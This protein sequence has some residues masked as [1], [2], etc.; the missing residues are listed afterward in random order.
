MKA[1]L[2]IPS[3]LV[4]V[5]EGKARYRCSYGGRGSGKTRT[6][7]LMTAV[8]GYKWGM[9]GNQGQILCLREFMN[10]LEDSSLEEIKSAIREVDWLNDYYEMGEKYIRSKDGKISYVFAGL[11]RNI[12]SLK[13]KSRIILAWVDEAESVS[14]MAWQKL[15]PTVREHDSEIW[16]T[17]N[18][19]S[20]ESATHKRFRE[21]P[22]SNCKVAELNYKDNPWFPDVLEQERLT[23]LEKRPEAYDHIW[24]GDFLT[25]NSGAYYAIEMRDCKASNRIGFVPYE[26]SLG[27]VTSW[28]LGIGDS[29]SIWFWQISGGGELRVIDYYENNGVGLDHYARV[30]QEKGYIYKEHILPHDVRVK[31][32]G[33]G[34]SRLETLDNLGIRPITIAPKLG[35]DDGIQAVRSILPRCWFDAEKT[36]RGID[37]LRQYHREYNEINKS[38]NGRPK[39]DWASHGADAFRYFAV[40]YSPISDN[41]SEPIKRRIRGVA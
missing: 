22:P 21:D 7:A 26:P 6:F 15:M 41:W 9:S 8:W 17:W 36:E 38:W 33:S 1:Q 30:L 5:F 29:S 27:V 40:G 37:C 25:H 32:L 13:S 14:E 10:S 34:K 4:P 16:V 2:K 23:D 19:E 12:D 11:R 3:K 18:P 31:E 24:E 20:K 28:D 35:V 39:H